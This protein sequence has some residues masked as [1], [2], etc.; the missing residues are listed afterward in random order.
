[1]VGDFRGEHSRDVQF[2]SVSVII[3]SLIWLVLMSLLQFCC[4]SFAEDKR[5][6]R[7]CEL[8]G[9]AAPHAF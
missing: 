2:C 6:N 9:S 5:P 1:M 3:D 7:D 4:P 8:D